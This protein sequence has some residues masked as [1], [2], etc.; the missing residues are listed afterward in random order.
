VF[1]GVLRET[2]PGER[3]VALVPDAVQQLVSAGHRVGIV[4]GAGSGARHDDGAYQAVGAEVFPTPSAMAEQAHVLVAVRMP[5]PESLRL[6]RPGTVLVGQLQPLVNPAAVEILAAQGIEAFSLDALPRISRAQSM[7]V[8]S[9]MSTVSGYRAVI[10]GAMLLERFFPMLMTAAG[11]VPPAKVLV[12]GAG[13]AGLQAIATAHRLGAVVQA[14]DARP[15][16]KE[17]VES[18]GAMFLALPDVQAEGAGGYARA[19]A[20]DEEERERQFLAGPV[21]AA[22]LVVTT[23]M[24]PGHRAPVLISE[25]MVAA[26]H[27]GAV[28]MDLAAEAGGNCALTVPGQRVVRHGVVVDGATD[29]PSQMAHPASQLFSRNIQ[30]FL[31]L[32]TSEGLAASE[33]GRQVIL[34]ADG[35]EIIRSTWI[36]RGGRIVHPAVAERLGRTPKAQA[37]GAEGQ[38]P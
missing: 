23:A 7:D 32:L 17:Q 14:F 13:V 33:D 8:L 1:I 10:V 26:M 9:A 5:D 36:T 4:A 29:F 18:L 31:R 35:D 30:N 34:P 12:I 28:V 3:R 11:T 20:A 16:V 27:P 24:V 21:K 38:Q 6:L 25:E 37:A 15:V 2:A 19:V 22:D